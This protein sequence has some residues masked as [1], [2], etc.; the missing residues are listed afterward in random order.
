M[1]RC[2]LLLLASAA[3]GAAAETWNCNVTQN[4]PGH[5]QLDCNG[6][7]F[8]PMHHSDKPQVFTQVWF[9]ICGCAF[10]C[11]LCAALAAGLTL[12]LTSMKEFEL[13]VLCN[14]LVDE[15]EPN[16]TPR[17]RQAAQRK[18]EY[19]Q[20][21]A[22]RILPLISG[23]FMQTAKESWAHALDP[24][25]QHYL[26]V[27]LLLLNATANEALPLFLDRLVPS[28]MACLLSV[29][30]VLFFGE[31]IP[32]AVFTGPR[33]LSLAAALSPLVGFAKRIFAPIVLPISLMLDKVLGH[34]EDPYSRAQI[35]ALIRTIHTQESNLEID[36]AN[37][38]QGVLEMHHKKAQDIAWPVKE[39]KMVPHDRLL[40]Q[41]CVNEIMDWGHSRLFI[42]RKDA[43][44]PDRKDDIIGVVLVKKL[45]GISVAP[46][47]VVHG[48]ESKYRIGNLLH[49]VKRPVVLS[50]N[51]NLLATL[52]KFQSG[53][54]HLAMISPR[55]DDCMEAL[56]CQV[57][58]PEDARPTMFC[59]LE[60][61]IEEMLKEEIYD[62]EDKELQRH[63]PVAPEDSSPAKRARNLMLNIKVGRRFDSRF[64]R[65]LSD[66]CKERSRT[67]SMLDV[68]VGEGAA[69]TPL[70]PTTKRLKKASSRG[71]GAWKAFTELPSKMSE[72]FGEAKGE[73]SAPY[74]RM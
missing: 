22:K 50:P 46:T 12:G 41:E 1:R 56:R 43:S 3:L 30:V 48:P 33:Q 52:N 54:C 39:A 74:T 55:P 16:A 49:A 19:D 7:L 42:Y 15:I 37:M 27:T 45:I 28:W 31:I 8:I 5:V 65:S 6:Q 72:H 4:Q 68:E 40:T 10:G 59:S 73:E 66:V 35:K 53:T 62:E 2:A 18:L 32:S 20:S 60:D 26:L 14:H 63:A 44:D 69:T 23:T 24:S 17:S 11:I 61:V 70:S 29:T 47:D 9:I 67:G 21:C 71:K 51:E 58:I 34:S 13:K 25:N 36:E 38:L 64:R 57:A